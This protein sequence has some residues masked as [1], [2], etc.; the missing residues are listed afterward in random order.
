MFLNSHIHK[1]LAEAHQH[2]LMDSAQH[3]RQTGQVRRRSGA[4]SFR[5]ALRRRGPRRQTGPEPWL[6][7]ARPFTA[8]R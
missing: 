4:R 3:Y 2:D 5:S 7:V 6:S 8:A 1:Q